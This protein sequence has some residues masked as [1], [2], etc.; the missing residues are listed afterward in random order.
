MTNVV[1]EAGIDEDKP[2]E[3]HPL[4]SLDD[5]PALHR[6]NGLAGSGLIQPRAG[7][8]LR[9]HLGCRAC[10]DPSRPVPVP[11]LDFDLSGHVAIVTGANQGIGAATAE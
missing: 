2:S 8:R 4:E 1:G 9:T 6:A 3:G 11:T 10:R 7:R 5:P